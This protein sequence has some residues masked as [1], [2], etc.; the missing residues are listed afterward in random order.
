MK[1]RIRPILVIAAIV[2]ALVSCQTAQKKNELVQTELA[3]WE[4]AQAPEDE[5]AIRERAKDML[6]TIR[7]R[8]PVYRIGPEDML[9]VAIWNRP[10]LSKEGRVRNDGIFFLPLIGNIKADGLSVA[11]LQTVL[12]E[13][14]GRLLRDPQVDVEIIEYGS[15]VYYVFGQVYK[16]GVYPVKATSS[17]LE[18]VAGAGGTTEKAN[19]GAAYLIRAGT[20]VPIDFYRLFER[21]DIGQNLLLADGDIIYVPDIADSKVYV[22][23]EVNAATAVPMRGTRMRLSEAVA[24]AGGF[25]EITAFKRGIK[26]IR[27]GL[28]N[29]RVYTV[30]YEDIRRGKVPDIA[31]LQNGDIVYVPAGGLTKWDRVM[32]QLLPNLSRIIVD[33]AAIDSLTGNR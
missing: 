28:G 25:N 22:L 21:G 19:L 33:A 9:R 23:G 4:N 6:D 8:R 12:R 20:V 5:Q 18:G 16:P 14:F 24:M 13:K 27:G 2:L 7:K 17:V 1:R 31:F 26:I 3:W 11:E 29:P 32:G 10:D 15:K 30:N